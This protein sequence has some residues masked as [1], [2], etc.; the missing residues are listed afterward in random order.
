MKVRLLVLSLAATV[1]LIGCAGPFYVDQRY[2]HGCIV[3]HRRYFVGREHVSR[4]I[5]L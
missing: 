4:R 5:R 3:T 1:V 2:W